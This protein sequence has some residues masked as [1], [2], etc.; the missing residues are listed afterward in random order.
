MAW[1]EFV[2][3]M[4]VLKIPLVYLCLVVR[5]AIRAE[6]E[7]GGGLAGQAGGD[8]GGPGGGWRSGFRR[9]GRLA[10]RGG[11][12]RTPPRP[13]RRTAFAQGRVGR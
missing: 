4:F 5:W 6:P 10:P 2:F 11:P 7:P 1:W 8:W 13:R 3:M 9:A 12:V